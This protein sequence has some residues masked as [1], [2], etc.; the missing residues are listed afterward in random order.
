MLKD[1]SKDSAAHRWLLTVAP[2]LSPMILILAATFNSP[3]KAEAAGLTKTNGPVKVEIL[4]TND[5][6]QL[7]VD[8]H[9]FYIKGAGMELGSQEKLV[10]HGGNSIRTWQSDGGRISGRK[11]LD[12][13][14]KNGLYVTMGLDIQRER[15]GFDYNDPAA[16]ARQL[17]RVKTEVLKYKDSPA[18]IIWAIGNELN[19]DAHNPKVW[20]AVN[21]ISKMIHQVDPNHLTTTPLAGFKPELVQLVK[22]RAPDLDLLSFQMYGDIIN[23]PR[24]LRESGWDGPYLVTEWGA[25]GHW[26][27]RKTAWGAPI[28]NDST[29]KADF[30]R[31][32]FLA[33]IWSD[34][35]EC[36]GSYVFLWGHKQERTPTWY[37]MFLA[38]GEETETIDVMHYLWRGEWPADRSP[39]LA[40]VKLDG[41][42]AMQNIHLKPGETY[43]AFVQVAETNQVPLAYTWTVMAESTDLHTGGD[44]ETQPKSFPGLVHAAD[45]SRVTV[46]APSEPGAYRLF[47]YVFAGHHAAYAN[48]PF[49][50]DPVQTAAAN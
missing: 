13:A 35:K 11:I 50:V 40:D 31:K 26:E 15:L 27:V 38:S 5:Q 14:V 33:S 32:R 20:D 21:D 4:H 30:Y 49:Y 42:T 17:A 1:I 36:L 45:Q 28:E 39:Q 23:L 46:T 18:L 19:L 2:T 41:K 44:F 43:P 25:T 16:V 3:L 12:N 7:L 47:T 9:P 37:G 29:T 6:Y 8:H 10:A 22:S 34:R 24:Y 48:I